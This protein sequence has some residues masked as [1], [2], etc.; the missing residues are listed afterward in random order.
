MA[1]SCRTRRWPRGASTTRPAEGDA[2]EVAPDG[3]DGREV[4]CG[5]V[6]GGRALDARPLEGGA[7]RRHD[8]Q[9]PPGSSRGRATS[10]GSVPSARPR[11]RQR[12]AAAAARVSRQ[13]VPQQ[14][15]PGLLGRP[16][17]AL[18]AHP[19][20][21]EAHHGP[22]RR[23]RPSPRDV[24]GAPALRL[25][26][27]EPPPRV[28]AA[29]ASR[30]APA[31][32]RRRR[33]DTTTTTRA[34][35]SAPRR[36]RRADAAPHAAPDAVAPRAPHHAPRD[37]A[38]RDR[39]G[40]DQGR[41]PRAHFLEPIAEELFSKSTSK[42]SPQ[43][44]SSHLTYMAK[45]APAGRSAG[46]APRRVSSDEPPLAAPLAARAKPPPCSTSRSERPAA[47]PAAATPAYASRR[48]RRR[49]R[50]RRRLRRR[51]DGAGRGRTAT[52]TLRGPGFVGF[53]ESPPTVSARRG[54][55]QGRST[56]STPRPLLESA[57][58]SSG[59]RSSPT[60]TRRTATGARSIADPYASSAPPRT[61][62]EGAPLGCG[63]GPR[64]AAA[65]TSGRGS[66][67]RRTSPASAR[68]PRD[69]DAAGQAVRRPRR[70]RRSRR[71][72][73]RPPSPRPRPRPRGCPGRV[74]AGRASPRR[75]ARLS[76]PP[77]VGRGRTRHGTAPDDRQPRRRRADRPPRVRA[78]RRGPRRGRRL[79][80]A[81]AAATRA[82]RG[83]SPPPTRPARPATRRP[84]RERRLPGDR[85]LQEAARVAAAHKAARHRRQEGSSSSRPRGTPRRP[86]GSGRRGEPKRRQVWALDGD[87]AAAPGPTTTATTSAAE[88]DD[89]D[90]DDGIGQRRILPAAT[91]RLDDGA[92]GD[93]D[94]DA[95]APTARPR[96]RHRD[97]RAAARP[98]PPARPRPASTPPRQA[99]PRLRPG[100]RPAREIVARLA[101]SPPGRLLQ[102]RELATRTP[103]SRARVADLRRRTACRLRPEG[104]RRPG[105]TR[106]TH[107]LRDSR[108]IIRECGAEPKV[109]AIAAA[110]AP[111]QGRGGNAPAAVVPH[112]T[113]SSLSADRAGPSSTVAPRTA[114]TTPPAPP[115]AA[116]RKEWAEH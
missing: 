37:A 109:G 1:G 91:S 51:G 26:P 45:V 38:H 3:I 57:A 28:P 22:P 113:C 72:A 103:R 18:D 115:G 59:R 114:S 104:G 29:S 92:D 83:K 55:L 107:P 8:A 69:P 77:A 41:H 87:D 34:P 73:R 20:R 33:P 97:D 60:A 90:G 79:P 9:A 12:T 39:L 100:R 27:Q 30:L 49:R 58:G 40:I 35:A 70:Q 82:R 76:P 44:E 42:F 6:A 112:R 93:G 84:G 16:R 31:P 66:R 52:T 62:D 14:P 110:S 17:A 46:C 106:E 67:P 32:P 65:A 99:R 56:S 81:R 2:D 24:R 61:Q 95:A 13:H 15:G 102:G 74:G 85:D 94:D 105:A 88:T 68:A 23:R 86:G 63:S 111:A 4:L 108:V 98:A 75:P 25:P 54:A 48:G 21:A 50:R 19:R 89:D 53:D 11:F 7:R 101:D 96:R 116:R 71:R 80:R 43:R 10:A 47:E 5:D 78:A 36:S 64:A